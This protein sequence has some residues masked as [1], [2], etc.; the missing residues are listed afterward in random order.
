MLYFIMGNPLGTRP[1]IKVIIINVIIN[2]VFIQRTVYT[3]SIPSMKIKTLKLLSLSC[4]DVIIIAHIVLFLMSGGR[5]F[6]DPRE[7]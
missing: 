3:G 7:T 1:P 4:T 6:H 5:K 2:M